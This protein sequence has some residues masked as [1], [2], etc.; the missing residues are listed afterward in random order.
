MT[1][2]VDRDDQEQPNS[3]KTTKPVSGQ[4]PQTP[5][6]GELVGTITRAI[7]TEGEIEFSRQYVN[8]FDGIDTPPPDNAHTDHEI[9]TAL[10]LP[11]II[12]HSSHYYAW[13]AELA[14]MH[15]GSRFLSQGEMHA[16][17]RAPVFP[18]DEL[19]LQACRSAEHGPHGID[20]TVHGRD[21]GLVA[22]AWATVTD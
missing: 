3:E 19:T 16:Q 18:G 21:H 11:D 12:A 1:A 20:I 7:T 6:D 5:D 13:C 2:S 8:R 17:F 15:Y 9:A 10:G 4:R 14:L 22:R